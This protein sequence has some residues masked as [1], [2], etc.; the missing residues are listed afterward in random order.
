M[1]LIPGEA[2]GTQTKTET[3][4]LVLCGVPGVVAIPRY[5]TGTGT[6]QYG[7]GCRRINGW[8]DFFVSL[9]RVY[10]TPRHTVSGGGTD[11][12]TSGSVK[13]KMW[14]IGWVSGKANRVLDLGGRTKDEVV[15]MLTRGKAG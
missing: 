8:A 5:G 4:L 11:R 10:G 15:Q 2:R 6:V 7:V 14:E 13:N 3:R 1:I 12:L 9:V